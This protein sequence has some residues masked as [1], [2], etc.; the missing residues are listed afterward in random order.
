MSVNKSNLYDKTIVFVVNFETTSSEI[1]KIRC[2]GTYAYGKTSG[3]MSLC[4]KITAKD[5]NFQIIPTLSGDE[6]FTI[7][8][9]GLYILEDNIGYDEP[10][11]SKNGDV[12]YGD[13]IFK[14]GK[15]GLKDTTTGGIK[16]IT[17]NNG[18]IKII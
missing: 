10:F 14:N 5:H 8:S 16:Y 2:G 3:Y 11:I 6:T 9:I 4:T 18:T 13:L 17:I 15:I 12:C 1:Q 7:K